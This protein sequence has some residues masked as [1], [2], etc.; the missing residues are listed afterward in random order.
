MYTAERVVNARQLV[1][2]NTQTRLEGRAN[3]CK[4][5]KTQLDMLHTPIYTTYRESIQLDHLIANKSSMI[6]NV[7]LIILMYAIHCFN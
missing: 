7:V 2:M 5:I 1:E 6:L 3:D 4:F